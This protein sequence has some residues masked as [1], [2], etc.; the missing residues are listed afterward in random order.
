MAT[1][2]IFCCST[3]RTGIFRRSTLRTSASLAVRHYLFWTMSF[4]SVAPGRGRP[5][6]P[7]KS[8]YAMPD[9]SNIRFVVGLT[10]G[11][12]CDKVAELVRRMQ[13]H[14]A[15]VDVV[16]TEAATHFTTP[17][18]MQALSGLP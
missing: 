8:E 4:V 16:M 11:V 9:L 5:R 7:D 6:P 2:L 17:T 14:G 10:G 12:S 18:T 3:G 15:D 13:D 1:S